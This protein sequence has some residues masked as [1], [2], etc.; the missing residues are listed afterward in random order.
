MSIVPIPF[1]YPYLESEVTTGKTGKSPIYR[2][3]P[4]LANWI[5][6]EL[7]KRL[8][9]VKEEEENEKIAI[10]CTRR[11]FRKCP[12]FLLAHPNPDGKRKTVLEGWYFRLTADPEQ[13]GVA[14]TLD[15][16]PLKRLFKDLENP[17]DQT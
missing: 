6:H 15:R 11:S 9:T 10:Y 1:D 2:V 17:L 12:V 13:G 16:V 8:N 7:L 3:S 5:E 14:L 4:Q